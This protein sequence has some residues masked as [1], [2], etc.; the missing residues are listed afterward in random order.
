[1]K[2][3]IF[4]VIISL[5]VW[6]EVLQVSKTHILKTNFGSDA[7]FCIIAYF[8]W[9]NISSFC[10]KVEEEMETVGLLLEAHSKATL[11]GFTLSGAPLSIFPRNGSFVE[12]TVGRGR[13]VD[14]VKQLLSETMKSNLP[15]HTG[16]C[17]NV[18]KWSE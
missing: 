12:K 14:R 5:E 16:T 9:T 17:Q 11:P 13:C 18:L 2:H 3:E 4:F 8:P 7:V 15:F 10:S 6:N 1:M